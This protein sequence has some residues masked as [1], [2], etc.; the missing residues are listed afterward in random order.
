[1]CDVS[2]V[3]PCFNEAQTLPEL[4]RRLAT[5]AASLEGKSLEFLFINDGSQD[6]TGQILDELA[7]NDARVKVL[8]FARNHGHQIAVTAGLDHTSGEAVIIMD[9][10]LQ[11]PP[12]LIDQYL[13]KIRQGYDIVHAKRRTRPGE[14]WFK[15]ATARIFYWLFSRF[16][17][18][19]MEEN[20]GDFRAITRRVVFTIREFR[21]PHRF[22]RALFAHVGFKQCV[23]L[24]DRD[25]RYAG[26]TK[27]PLPKMIRLALNATM[28]FSTAPLRLVFIV[29]ML[30][31]AGGALYASKALYERFVLGITVPG[32]ASL[33]VLS[34]FFTGLILLA[35]SIVGSYVSRVFEQGQA[36]PMYWLRDARNLTADAGAGVREA[37]LFRRVLETAA[38]TRS[39]EGAHAQHPHFPTRAPSERDSNEAC[40]T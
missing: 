6:A 23:I 19:G 27:Y 11:D 13:H 35:L 10:D 16:G 8:H 5:V 1:M 14:T 9:A 31:W 32:W 33:I 39:V 7:D 36:R 30:L 29:S 21:E 40:L 22:L 26:E 12:E 20:C 2:Y 24:Y 4:Y 34:T 3:I 37:D 28:S 25:P 15:K 17:E 38:A 18:R